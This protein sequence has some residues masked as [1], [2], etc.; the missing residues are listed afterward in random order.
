MLKILNLLLKVSALK[1]CVFNKILKVEFGIEQVK[2]C[3]GYGNL[4]LILQ[5]LSRNKLVICFCLK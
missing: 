3:T 5:W 4:P 1:V 2:F